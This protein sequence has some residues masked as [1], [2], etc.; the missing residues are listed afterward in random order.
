[1]SL[2][3]CV[4]YVV[5]LVVIAGVLVWALKAWPGFDDA[6]RQIGRIVIIVLFVVA[7]VLV[8]MNCLGL[9]GATWPPLRQ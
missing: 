5:L 2:I 4:L 8:L 6:I 9:H 7:M 1:M 3:Q